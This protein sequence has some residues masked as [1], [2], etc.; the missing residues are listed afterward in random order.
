MPAPFNILYYFQN[1]ETRLLTQRRDG[2]TED[3]Y[4]SYRM[5]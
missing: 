3:K 5:C 2:A 1:P 4:Q